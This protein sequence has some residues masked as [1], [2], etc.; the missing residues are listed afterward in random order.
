MTY[1]YYAAAVG[2]SDD[3]NDDW[4]NRRAT[5]RYQCALA[6]PG[7]VVDKTEESVEE[8][9]VMDLSKGGAGV[10]MEKCLEHGLQVTLQISN[11]KGKKY[12]ILAQ[13][14]HTT[15]RVSGDWII[16]FAFCQSFDH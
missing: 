15:E 16:G 12:E 4:T 3:K 5:V 1:Q 7:K 10:V 14:A 6:T 11:S 2:S 13:V 9:W 8:V